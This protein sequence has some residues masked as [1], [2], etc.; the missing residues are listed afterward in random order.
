MVELYLTEL[1]SDEVV[2]IQKYG[3]KMPARSRFLH[4]EAAE[5]YRK[6]LHPNGMVVSDMFRTP[7]SSLAAVAAKR[8]AQRPGYSAHNYGLAI[9]I[10]V[11]VVMRN[12]GLKTKAKLDAWMEERG[13]YCHL[14]NHARDWEE[15]HYNFLGIGTIISPKVR[16][17]MNYI[18]A[19]IDKLHGN[20]FQ[21]DHTEVQRCLKKLNF[22]NG[23]ID[24]K[25]GP[26]SKAA[27]AMFQRSVDLNDTGRPDERTN[28]TLAYCACERIIVPAGEQT[29]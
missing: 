23:E 26:I 8:G 25:F 29:N 10:D 21:L 7:E 9:D 24:G 19:K 5:S 6:E 22:Y 15:W 16:T 4:P 20:E 17:T 11:T 18:E 3:G 2:G 14:R 12:L 1:D 28:R 13:W 27:L